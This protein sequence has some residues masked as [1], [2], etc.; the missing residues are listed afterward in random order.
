M[1]N[2]LTLSFISILF[3]S[4]GCSSSDDNNSDAAAFL[5]QIQGKWKLT[6]YAG[7]TPEEYVEI[8]NGWEMELKAD[9]TFTST[10]VPGYIGG[11]YSVITK[12]GHNIRLVFKNSSGSKV[13][14]KHVEY[15]TENGLSTQHLQDTPLS[16]EFVYFAVEGLTRIP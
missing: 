15:M 4:V 14:Y 12:P 5:Q 16:D 2:L 6:A 13:F 9:K 10:E 1:K 8:Q 11:K 3:L 7:D